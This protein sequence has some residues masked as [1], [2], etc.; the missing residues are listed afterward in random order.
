MA[1]QHGSPMGLEYTVDIDCKKTNHS[2]VFAPLEKQA[3]RETT[4]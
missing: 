3:E 1:G 4:G 2:L